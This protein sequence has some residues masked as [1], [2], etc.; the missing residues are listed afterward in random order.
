MKRLALGTE[1]EQNEANPP[2][3]GSKPVIKSLYFKT[4][5]GSW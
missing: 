5:K 2:W 4:L 1:Q 3:E